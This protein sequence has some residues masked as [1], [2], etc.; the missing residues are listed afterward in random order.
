[1]K[2]K[3]KFQEYAYERCAY[4]VCGTCIRNMVWGFL[5]EGMER[6]Q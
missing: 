2:E 5:M 1:M 6:A 4:A 3:I